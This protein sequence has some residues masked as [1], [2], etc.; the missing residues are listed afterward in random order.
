VFWRLSLAIAPHVALDGAMY[1][2]LSF[3][4]GWFHDAVSCWFVFGFA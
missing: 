2:A 3:I 1:V 4:G